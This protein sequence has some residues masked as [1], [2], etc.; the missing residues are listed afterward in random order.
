MKRKTSK[1]ADK[2]CP[3]GTRFLHAAAAGGPGGAVKT[4]KGT[5]FASHC[6]SAIF[7]CIGASALRGEPARS[8]QADSPRTPDHLA[9]ASI[10]S[11][12]NAVLSAG[13]TG[14]VGTWLTHLMVDAYNKNGHPNPRVAEFLKEA[15]LEMCDPTQVGK[16]GSVVAGEAESFNAQGED[17]P[18]FYLAA[19]IVQKDKLRESQYMY[20][21]M[22]GFSERPSS[23]FLKFI[24]SAHLGMGLHEL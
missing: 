11:G 21:A 2:N 14:R 22:E 18:I 12:T 6:L 15:I 17:D 20:K 5:G 4:M 24:A 23:D 19:G 3:V 8:P 9:G 10:P 7:I 13:F 1:L 16:A